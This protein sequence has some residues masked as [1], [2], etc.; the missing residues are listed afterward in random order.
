MA[1]EVAGISIDALREED[2]PKAAEIERLSF[3]TPWSETLFFN[4][5]KNPRCVALAARKER[6][7]VGYACGGLIID[8]GHIHNLAVS[9]DFRGKGIAAALVKELVSLLGEQGARF[10]FL[11]VRDSNEA[12]KSLYRAFGFEVIGTRK[13]YYVSPV[14]HA[15]V[16]RLRLGE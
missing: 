9:P 5:L 14:E 16:M 2:I 10:I 15:V 6:L 7:L 13:D 1:G 12:A 3:S 11:E 4:E 8:E